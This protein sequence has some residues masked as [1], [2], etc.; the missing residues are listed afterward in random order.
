MKPFRVEAWT[1]A[2]ANRWY[3]Q[4]LYSGGRL[5]LSKLHA[6][7]TYATENLIWRVIMWPATAKVRLLMWGNA[8]FS[9]NKGLIRRIDRTWQG[10]SEEICSLFFCYFHPLSYLCTLAVAEM[11][12]LTHTHTHTRPGWECMLRGSPARPRCSVWCKLCMCKKHSIIRPSIIRGCQWALS[13]WYITLS[14][15]LP[16]LGPAQ[17]ARHVGNTAGEMYSTGWDPRLGEV[18]RFI[19]FF[20][21]F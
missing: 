6:A 16:Q 5:H 19:C 7:A 1:T 8:I 14:C 17:P 3:L 4:I 10:R 9:P 2:G 12:T 18:L 20:L 11:S 21:F 15:P 13:G